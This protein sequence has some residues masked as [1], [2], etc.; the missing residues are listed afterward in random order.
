MDPDNKIIKLSYTCQTMRYGAINPVN[1]Y[2]FLPVSG[3]QRRGLS[4]SAGCMQLIQTNNAYAA[5]LK[6]NNNGQGRSTGS[7]INFL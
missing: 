4:M 7:Q 1:S 5:A 2:C 3:F 6:V